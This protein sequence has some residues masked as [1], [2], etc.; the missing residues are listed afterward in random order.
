MCGLVALVG[1]VPAPV[2]AAAVRGASRRGPHS[3]GWAAYEAGS[4]AGWAVVRG[5]GPLRPPPALGGR[6]VGHSRLATNGTAPGDVP[7]LDESMPF[8]ER[9]HLFAHNGVVY[10]GWW[11]GPV[12]VDSLAAM[13]RGLAA[14]TEGGA[15]LQAGL[16]EASDGP[17]AAVWGDPEGRL[18]AARYAGRALPPQ[19]LYRASGAGW[20]AVSSGVLPNGRLV[21]EGVTA[22]CQNAS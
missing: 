14:S 21:P 8:I 16:E 12:T 11:Y 17:S 5:R 13:L 18:W 22:L 1:P 4:D 9:G 3:H 15:A 6:L 20:T 2:A 7:P 19:P 10:D